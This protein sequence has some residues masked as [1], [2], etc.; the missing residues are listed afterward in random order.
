MM[1]G[2]QRQAFSDPP[3]RLSALAQYERHAPS[4]DEE[5][6]W[7]A[8]DRAR[9][10]ELLDLRPGESVIDVGCGT[11]LCIP[12]LVAGVGRRGRV[13]GIEQ[14]I[15][16]LGRAK[17]RADDSGWGNVD[18]VLG[19]VEEVRI[20][21]VADAALFSFTH[22]VLRN[23]AALENV[24]SN[25]RPGGRVAAVGPMWAPWWAPAMNM[26][27]WYVTSDFVTTF[28]GF[29]EPWGHLAR[30]VPGLSVTRQELLGRYF[31]WGSLPE[32]ERQAQ[33]GS[34]R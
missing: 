32:S 16:M 20:P 11:G 7:V 33:S 17:E 9:V 21:V 29:S 10:V 12:L 2:L 15:D 8:S 24:L 30:R 3:D 28:E 19:S 14:S 23:E 5:T 1:S 25:L 18:L 22:D 4:Y 34:K 6:D 26:L 31:A 13:V 27:I